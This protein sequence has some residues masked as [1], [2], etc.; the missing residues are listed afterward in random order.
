M[1]D[2]ILDSNST[3]TDG[4]FSQVKQQASRKDQATDVKI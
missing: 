2:V 3:V 1:T 4:F